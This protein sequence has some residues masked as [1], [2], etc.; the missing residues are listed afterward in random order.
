MDRRL[1]RRAVRID[2]DYNTVYSLYEDC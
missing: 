2:I 1:Q